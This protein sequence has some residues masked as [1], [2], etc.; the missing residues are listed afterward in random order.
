MEKFVIITDSC[1]DLSGELRDRYGIEYVPMYFSCDERE[2]AADLDYKEISQKDFYNLMRDGKRVIT[3]QANK[4]SYREVFRKYAEAGVGVLSV[5]C[6]SALSASVKAS[7]VARDEVLTEFPNAEIVCIDTLMSGSG[8]G[9]IA[10]KASMMRESGATLA[11]CA[12]WIEENKLNFHQEGCVDSLTYLK[13][14]GRVSAASAFFGGILSVKP[15]IISDAKGRN[16]AAEKVKG[17]RASIKRLAE[18]FADEYVSSE[19]P[20][21][22]SHADCAEDAEALKSEVLAKLAE[23]GVDTDSLTFY[24]EY[25]GPI[26]GASVGPGTVAVWF[27]GK[28]VTLGSEE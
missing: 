7:L 21:I 26:V 18:R 19:L 4:E 11:E 13:R 6:S 14:A 8:L 1:S 20:I 17:R 5:S 27:Y 25:I 9:L 28:E 10:I 22:F 12:Q 23:M 2:Y 16:I 15:I 24:T 3:S